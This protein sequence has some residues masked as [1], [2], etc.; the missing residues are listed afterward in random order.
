MHVSSSYHGAFFT[1]LQAMSP[2]YWG[3]DMATALE[4]GM[5]HCSQVE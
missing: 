4:F 1:L 5:R 2:G 3:S